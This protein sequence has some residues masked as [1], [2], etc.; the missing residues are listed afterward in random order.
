MP[1]IITQFARM[2]EC[3]RSMGKARTMTSLLEGEWVKAAA[4]LK[5]DC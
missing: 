1:S 5:T 2:A 3:S 4:Q